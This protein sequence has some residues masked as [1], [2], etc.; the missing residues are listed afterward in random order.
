M[1]TGVQYEYLK[2]KLLQG[3]SL[4]N[5]MKVNRNEKLDSRPFSILSSNFNRS[6]AWMSMVRKWFRSN[7]LFDKPLLKGPSQ[8]SSLINPQM[9]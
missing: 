9:I 5:M 4:S 2:I 6:T 1:R 7:H 8:V 3:Y